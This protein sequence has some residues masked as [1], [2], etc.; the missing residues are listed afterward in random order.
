[1][2]YQEHSL[3]FLINKLFNKKLNNSIFNVLD[4]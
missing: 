3:K 1:M 2:M 4:T